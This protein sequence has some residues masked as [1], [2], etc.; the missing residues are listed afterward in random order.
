MIKKILIKIF[1]IVFLTSCGFTPMYSNLGTNK[2]NIQVIN[3]SGDNEINSKIISKLKVHNNNS[4]KLF[5]IKLNTE[6][7][8]SDL[9]KNLKGEVT[10]YQLNAITNYKISGENVKKEFN[11]SENFIMKNFVDNF[12]E[13]NYE[14]RLKENIANVSYQKLML[15]LLKLK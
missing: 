13:K 3:T 15:Q 6:Y 5:K 12:E 9:S 4:E 2:L 8:K 7:V 14:K 11:I 1:C 10:Q